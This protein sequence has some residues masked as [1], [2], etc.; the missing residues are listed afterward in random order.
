MAS[1]LPKQTARLDFRLQSEHKALVERAASAQGQTVTQFAIAT[2][3]KA[4][5]ESIQQA[6]LTEL[7][8]R[9]R[10][11]FLEMLDS[12]AEPNAALKKAAKRYRA[13]RG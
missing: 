6:A 8:I 3:V 11:V 13:L 1:A 4:A 9:D 7:S 2:L 10:D 12:D 5:H